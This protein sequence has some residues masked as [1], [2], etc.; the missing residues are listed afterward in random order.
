[1]KRLPIIGVMG[2]GR[3]EHPRAAQLG[4]WL[5][6]RPVHLLTGGGKGVMTAVSRA[7]AESPERAGMVIGVLPSAG[8]KPEPEAGYPNA[9][10][11][12]PI[13]THLPHSGKR[14]ESERSR[15]HINVLSSD[16]VIALPGGEGTASEVRLALRYGRPLAAFIDR[17]DEIPGIPAEVPLTRT[18]DE[19]AAFVDP[20]LR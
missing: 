3:E 8:A 9:W 12:I 20:L 4:A 2:S 7:F 13:V 10:V 17:R 6:T 1:M 5:A 16:V 11:E 15:N 19:L 18:L 14:G